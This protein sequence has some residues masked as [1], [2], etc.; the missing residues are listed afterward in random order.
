[1]R[2]RVTLARV[3]ADPEVRRARTGSDLLA[4]IDRHGESEPVSMGRSVGGRAAL[5]RRTY[6]QSIAW[7]GA[8]MAEALEHDEPRQESR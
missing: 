3:L 5:S 2:R 6:A 1:M 4:S 8:R 7:W